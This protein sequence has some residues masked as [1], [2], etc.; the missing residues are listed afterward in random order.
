MTSLECID[1]TW[2]VIDDAFLDRPS[3]VCL[4]DKQ[5]RHHYL[6]AMVQSQQMQF[7]QLLISR[8]LVHV[9]IACCALQWHEVGDKQY[10]KHPG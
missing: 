3:H 9:H 2:H 5:T 4:C 7:Q 10:Q 6:F 8:K 1:T